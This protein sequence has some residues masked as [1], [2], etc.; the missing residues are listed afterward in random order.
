MIG[1][2]N[3]NKFIQVQCY[4]TPIAFYNLVKKCVHNS[5]DMRCFANSLYE[6]IMIR[7]RRLYLNDSALLTGDINDINHYVCTS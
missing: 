3:V 6:L 7:E 4:F 1:V 5:I 2:S